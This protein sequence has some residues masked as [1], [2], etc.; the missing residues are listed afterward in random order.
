MYKPIFLSNHNQ[1]HFFG[2]EDDDFEL[3]NSSHSNKIYKNYTQEDFSKLNSC[4]SYCPLYRCNPQTVMVWIVNIETGEKVL[5]R[6][7]FDNCSNISVLKQSVAEEI[8]I[9]GKSCHLSFTGTGSLNNEFYNRKDV[10]FVIKDVFGTFQTEPIQAVTLPDVSFGFERITIDPKEHSHLKTINNFTEPLPM[11]TK[12]FKKTGEVSI[13][14]GLP[15]ESFYGCQNSTLPPQGLGGPVA[16]HTKLG[17]CITTPTKLKKMNCKQTFQDPDIT[18]LM[19]LDVLGITD[20]PEEN[21]NLTYEEMQAEQIIKEK[22]TYDVEKNQYC[23]PLLWKTNEKGEPMKIKETNMNRAK[24]TAYQWIKKLQQK[25]PPLIDH[26][27][28]AGQDM[29]DNNFV[30]LVPKSD[31]E[32]TEN[33]HYIQ[34]FPVEQSHKP[35]HPAR[36]VFAANQQMKDSKKSLNQHLMQGPNHLQE[37]VKILLRFRVYPVI[38]NMDVSKFFLRTL[39]A[40][41]DNDYL[42]FFLIKRGENGQIKLEHARCLGYPWG[43]CSSPFVC[44][45]LMKIHAQK[46]LQDPEL[47]EASKQIIL[48]SYVDDVLI[49]HVDEEKL[50]DLAKKA[51]KILQE[52]SLPTGKYLSNSKKVLEAF[53]KEE[54]SK[55]S[56]I[57]ILGAQWNAEEDVITFNFIKPPETAT[58]PSTEQE[59][60]I[61]KLKE[62]EEDQ[63]KNKEKEDK[64]E[65]EGAIY[66]KRMV[67]STQ[68]RIFDP[69]GMCSAYSL[70]P[71]LILQ[72]AWQRQLSWDQQL[73]QDLNERFTEFLQ[74]LPKLESIKVNR[75]LLATPKSKVVEVFAMGDASMNAY[76]TCVYLITQDEELNRKS[77]LVFSKS[78]VRPL[79]KKLQILNDETCPIAR[80]ELLAALITCKAGN[81]IK[82]ALEEIGDLKAENIKIK[83]FSDSQVTLWRIRKKYQVF[84]VWVA[85]R[86]RTIQKF[87]NPNDW[88]YIPTELNFASDSASRGRKLEEFINSELWWSGPEFFTDPNHDY[89]AMQITN[90]Q[91]SKDTARLLKE[92]TK[93]NTPYFNNQLFNEEEGTFTFNHQLNLMDLME[94]DTIS[95]EMV[96]FYMKINKKSPKEGGLVQRYHSW[97]KLV[98]VTARIIQF[99]KAC[100]KGWLVKTSKKP[101]AEDLTGLDMNNLSKEEKKKI[102]DHLL[103]SEEIVEAEKFLFRLA[104][105]LTMREEII[106]IRSAPEKQFDIPLE[107]KSN[108]YQLRPFW[109]PQD[110]L[111]RMRSRGPASNL[112]ILPKQHLITELYVRHHHTFNN[113]CGVNN[114]RSRCEK[115]CY[116]LGGQQEYKRILKCCVCRSPKKLFQEMAPLPIERWPKVLRVWTY[117]ATDYCG[118]VYYYSN[119]GKKEHKAWIALFTDLISRQIHVEVVQDC[120]TQALLLAI[121]THCSLNG[122]FIKCYSDNASYYKQSGKIVKD[123]LRKIDWNE[124]RREL[125]KDGC[126]FNVE[127]SHFCSSNPAE[128]GVIEKMV[129]VFKKALDSALKYT[130]RLHKTPMY[131]DYENLRVVCYEIAALVNDRPLTTITENINGELSEIHLTPS[132]LCKGRINKAFPLQVNVDEVKNS[133][134]FDIK[135]LYRERRKLLNYFWSEYVAGY[136]RNLHIPPKWLEKFESELPKHSFVLLKEPNLKTGQFITGRIVETMKRKDGKIARVKLVTTAHKG[137]IERSIRQIYLT[138]H[139]YLSLTQNNH[140][141]FINGAE[142]KKPVN[143]PIHQV[144]HSILA[145]PEVQEWNK[146]LLEQ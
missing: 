4:A 87:S 13:L 66:T 9:V 12:Q 142:Y 18:Q 59:T 41:E 118:P 130:Y 1:F 28:K 2:G 99:I 20:F 55:K 78:R 93:V 72:S 145:K 100:K 94:E 102:N 138:E 68:A 43:L 116:I 57:S 140:E 86:I 119:P 129:G 82:N 58:K 65:D 35:S 36:L 64:S 84:K 79:G 73:D 16:I 15:Y 95:Q 52:A 3:F 22:A 134:Q 19:R 88:Y 39:V 108:L 7:I 122:C 71:K 77:T 33:F 38:F 23:A 49:G 21:G 44:C 62:E 91:I 70:V 63:D 137:I 114:V 31:L 40:K 6:L 42:R 97:M 141:C 98:F 45:F 89:A 109:D 127:W 47:Q 123:I 124:V 90:I 126:D 76:S 113:H 74:E 144:L 60:S 61:D 132:L 111:L 34:S 105:M 67:L 136:R 92:E 128:A 81:F 24:A 10:Q 32:K 14:L 131:F 80:M 121:R 11:T 29:I 5:K 75:C 103:V 51:K 8:G 112:V 135:K 54:I 101:K 30:E 56:Q 69:L 50:L 143:I 133:G 96:D 85:N 37:L 27:I 120:T 117:I 110:S 53:S 83:F 107:K 17:S 48:N 139:D 25:N 146:D 46:Y 26:W 125:K 115:T 104:Q 106:S